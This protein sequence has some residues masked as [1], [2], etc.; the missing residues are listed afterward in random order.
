LKQFQDLGH[1]VIFLIGDF[2]GMIGDPSG[3]MESRKQLTRQEVLKN[4]ETYKEQIFKILDPGRT[5]IDFNSR[6]CSPMSFA[7]VL[8]L[9]SKYTIA[10]LLERD[11]FADRY[12]KNQPISVL[13]FLYPLIQGYDS[14]ALRADVELGGTDQIFNLLV[15]RELQ[16]EYGQEPQVVITM[17]LLVGTDGVEKMSKSLGN[18]I[19]IDEPPREM[20]G[21]TMSISDEIIMPYLRLLTDVPTEELAEMEQQMQTGQIN[22]R[23]VKMRLAREIVTRYHREAAAMAAQ[24]EFQRVFQERGLPDEMPEYRLTAADEPIW[25]VRL[26]VSAGLAATNGEARRLIAQ[27]GVR[28][29]GRRLD[30]D[31]LELRVEREMLIKVGKKRFLKVLPAVREE[32]G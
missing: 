13:E 9:A 16:R 1:E 29:D 6:W 22:P 20:F 8:T 17:P 28:I 19:G 23:D 30:D 2:T 26:M 10:R 21:K 24:E 32:R 5:V 25:V 7:D 12:K 18:Y 4:A 14:V 11:D 31:S 27:G 15:G 3:K